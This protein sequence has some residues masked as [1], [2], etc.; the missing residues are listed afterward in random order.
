M[1]NLINRQQKIKEKGFKIDLS[2]DTEDIYSTS[3]NTID[4]SKIKVGVKTLEDATVV[5]GD[6]KKANAR[7]S[8]K[9]NILKAINNK[10]FET[11]REAS[12]F[13]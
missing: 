4:F 12:N 9:G 2:D 13:Y 6:I 3:Y 8:D 11:M 10:D 1:L 5:L 7:L